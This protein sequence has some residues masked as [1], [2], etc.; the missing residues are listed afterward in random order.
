MEVL[1]KDMEE[2]QGR[3]H[4]IIWDSFGRFY[5]ELLSYISIMHWPLEKGWTLGGVERGGEI[6]QHSPNTESK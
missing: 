5:G 4:V 3:I 2:K 1:E 6:L